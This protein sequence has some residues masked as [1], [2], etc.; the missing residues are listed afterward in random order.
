VRTLRKDR[1]VPPEKTASQ[2]TRTVLIALG[3]NALIAAVKF[4][5]ALLT[6]S[7]ALFAEGVHSVAD[8]L[9]E[10]FLL[11]SLKKS[12]RPADARHPFGYGKERFFWSLLAAVGIF[13]AGAGFSTIEAYQAFTG[14]ETV[15]GHYFLIAYVA[16]AIAGAA[17][18]TSW[19]RAVR[20]V[21]AEARKAGRTPLEHVRK[22]SDPSVKTVASED[23]AALVGILFAFGGIALHQATGQGWWEGVAAALIALLLVVTAYLLGHDVKDMLIGE[24]VE[25]ELRD[26]LEEFLTRYDG[27]DEVV[28][29]LTMRMGA[30][31][32]LLAARIDLD[33]GLD[34]DRVEE[35][36][37]C[38]DHEINERWPRITQ[39]FLDA[40]RSD[41]RVPRV[42]LGGRVS[43]S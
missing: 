7:S 27:V 17:E 26:E 36:S 42:G 5:A 8:T 29:L 9:N 40:T 32:V 10:G 13:V 19:A 41:E 39:V 33:Q 11:T 1:T 15:G 18:G 25:P 28:D 35:I 22:S 37:T 2:S 23:T 20:Q 31:Q 34:S 24:A 4:V 38:I 12:S 16:L 21:R 14:H 3:A 30:D 6:G 43:G